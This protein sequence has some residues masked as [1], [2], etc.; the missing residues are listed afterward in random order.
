MGG[1]GAAA[2][3]APLSPAGLTITHLLRVPGEALTEK[4]SS[5]WTLQSDTL[6]SVQATPICFYSGIRAND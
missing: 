5:T 2:C 4:S 6:E 1:R 3:S